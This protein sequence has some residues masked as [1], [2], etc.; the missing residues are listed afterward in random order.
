MGNFE[1]ST[2]IYIVQEMCAKASKTWRLQRCSFMCR[3]RLDHGCTIFT[4]VMHLNLTTHCPE[5]AV[6]GNTPLCNHFKGH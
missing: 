3:C 2:T 4:Q 6:C 5:V 1:D